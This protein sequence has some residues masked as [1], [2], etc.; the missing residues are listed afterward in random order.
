M[1]SNIRTNQQGWSMDYQWDVFVSYRRDFPYGQWVRNVFM[2]LFRAYLPEA[3]NRKAEIFFDA[4]D[5]HAGEAFPEKL[6]NALA[7]SRCLLAFWLP[8]YF[9]DD[10]WCRRE[11]GA[12]LRRERRHGFRTFQN[13]R[14]LV[15]PFVLS[16][17]DHF[18]QVARETEFF[19]CHEYSYLNLERIKAFVSFQKSMRETWVQHVVETI[20]AAPP[21]SGD[22]M[23]DVQLGLPDDVLPPNPPRF[24]APAM[25]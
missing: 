24:A 11:W 20:H 10:G 2:P 3:L 9:F 17:G 13:P 8:S 19:K 25:G 1:A 5:I 21:W 14:S 16:D 22:W 6:T 18:P 12:F 4:S 7:H 15:V 23:Q